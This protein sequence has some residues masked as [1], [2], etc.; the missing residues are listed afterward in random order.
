MGPSI[1]TAAIEMAKTQDRWVDREVHANLTPYERWITRHMPVSIVRAVIDV[2]VE[3]SNIWPGADPK[4]PN[5][6]KRIV[7]YKKGKIVA[8]AQF[9]FAEDPI[10]NPKGSYRDDMDIKPR[11]RTML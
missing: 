2:T 10:T 5:G 4:H 3:H 7:I 6:I 8:H 11:K 9:A 1:D